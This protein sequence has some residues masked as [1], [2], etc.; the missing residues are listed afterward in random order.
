MRVHTDRKQFD[1]GMI[2]LIAITLFIVIA[3]AY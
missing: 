2:A 1:G 3:F